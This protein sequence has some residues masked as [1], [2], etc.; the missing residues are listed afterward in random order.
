MRRAFS[1]CPACG[2]VVPK[3]EG[4]GVS[5]GRGGSTWTFCCKT[6]GLEWSVSTNTNAYEIATR[7]VDAPAI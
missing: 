3:G 6:C 7:G 5:E 4:Y 2:W 1:M